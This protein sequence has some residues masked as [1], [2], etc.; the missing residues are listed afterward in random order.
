MIIGL[1]GLI[2]SGKTTVANCF[3]E[4][5]IDI[6][7]TDIIAHTITKDDKQTLMEIRQE[8][9]DEVFLNET[10]DRNKL[11]QVVFSDNLLRVKLENILHPKIFNIVSN[12]ISKSTQYS[13]KIVVVPLLFRSPKYLKLVDRTIFVDSDY[14]ILLDRL[15]IRSGLTPLEVDAILQQQVTREEQINLANDI[16]INNSNLS[17]IKSQVEILHAKYINMVR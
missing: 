15:K 10:L 7:D 13:Y 3:A 4:Y 11:R 8:F 6:I 12:K 17:A 16:I 1:T 5:G 2:G 9:G 14:K